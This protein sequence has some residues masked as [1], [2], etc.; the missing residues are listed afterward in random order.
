LKTESKILLVVAVF[1]FSLTLIYWFWSK[2]PAGALMLTGSFLLGLV[3]GLYYLWWSHRMEPRPE[4]L[5]DASMADGAGVIAAFPNGSIWPFVF[6]T[7]ATLVGLAFV[8][9]M[10]TAFVGLALGVSAM[11]GVAVESRRGGTV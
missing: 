9:G 11:I 10:W 4:D 1:F 8:L 6:G 5:E 3:P 7:G 2:E